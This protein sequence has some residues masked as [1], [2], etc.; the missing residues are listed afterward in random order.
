MCNAG[1]G[2]NGAGGGYYT[3]PA[4]AA[5]QTAEKAPASSAEIICH[6]LF[7]ICKVAFIITLVCWVVMAVGTAIVGP[8]GEA[9]F[10]LHGVELHVANF[11]DMAREDI[12]MLVHG[13]GI[14]LGLLGAC[15]IVLGCIKR[16]VLK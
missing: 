4:A 16:F 9:G 3:V 14:F 8:G 11:G 10:T 6:V 5:G 1:C 2:Y 7:I 13:T 15:L 12:L